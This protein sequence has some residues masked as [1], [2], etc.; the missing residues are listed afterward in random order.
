MQYW[1]Y[2]SITCMLLYAS[3]V[4][5]HLVHTQNDYIWLHVQYSYKRNTSYM[6]STVINATQVNYSTRA[7]GNNL[8]QIFRYITY[9]Q[10]GTPAKYCYRTTKE[11]TLLQ[12]DTRNLHCLYSSLILRHPSRF[13]L[14]GKN[15]NPIFLKSGQ[16]PGNEASL[17]AH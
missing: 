6:Y 5:T 15:K 7:N 2:N 8:V 14:A 12:N 16:R 9:I 13:Y 10:S 11:C 4:Y 3:T 1:A 17:T